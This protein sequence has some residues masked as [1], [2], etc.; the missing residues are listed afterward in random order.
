MHYKINVVFSKDEDGYYVYC[1]ELPGCQS[2]GNTFEEAK[3][4]IKEAIDLY[5]ETMSG[6]EIKEALSKELF[7]TTMEVSVG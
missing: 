7:T 6:E 3:E 1:P 4:N 5:I 2:Q